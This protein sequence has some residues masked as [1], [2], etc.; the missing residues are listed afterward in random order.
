MGIFS[1]LLVAYHLIYLI[2]SLFT[3]K[4]LDIKRVFREKMQKSNNIVI[5]KIFST[6]TYRVLILCYNRVIKGGLIYA[7]GTNA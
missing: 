5:N 4:L 6:L 1:Y 3:P 7:N 2:L